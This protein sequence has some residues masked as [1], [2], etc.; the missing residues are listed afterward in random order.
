LEG[1]THLEEPG[2]YSDVQRR[3]FERLVRQGFDGSDAS[4]PDRIRDAELLALHYAADDALAAVAAL[5]TPD[6][7]YRNDLF[8]RAE[9]RVN[10]VDYALELGWVFVV[11]AHRGS[12]IGERLCRMLLERASASGVFATTRPDNQAMITILET[13]GFA[14]IGGPYR[15]SRRNEELALFVRPR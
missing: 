12:R 11:P 2:A 7:R 8:K 15:H 13:L 6:E 3:E 4:L 9:A 10:P 14:R 1:T 5:K